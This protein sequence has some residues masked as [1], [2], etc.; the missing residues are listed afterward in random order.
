MPLTPYVLSYP[1]TNNLTL[2]VSWFPSNGTQFLLSTSIATIFEQHRQ[3]HQQYQQQR[4]TQISI[5]CTHQRTTI[6]TNQPTNCTNRA[7]N[8][9]NQPTFFHKVQRPKKSTI[10]LHPLYLEISHLISPHPRSVKAESTHLTYPHLSGRNRPVMYP[11]SWREGRLKQILFLPK[12]NLVSFQ[13]TRRLTSNCL[14]TYKSIFR[15]TSKTVIKSA[16]V[17]HERVTDK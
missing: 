17:S 14:L 11:F 10:Y 16:Q 13:T 8:C 6:C 3:Q 2:L 5:I 7:T 1:K 4:R 9:T 12:I 15:N